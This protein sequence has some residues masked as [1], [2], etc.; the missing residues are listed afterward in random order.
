MAV[1]G[2]VAVTS[3]REVRGLRTLVVILLLVGSRVLV[4]VMEVLPV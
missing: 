3:L 1:V 4:S 2:L